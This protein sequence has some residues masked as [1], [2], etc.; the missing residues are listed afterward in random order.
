MNNLLWIL[1][2]LFGFSLIRQ[3]KAAQTLVFD[4]SS[5]QI[6]G[7]VTNPILNVRVQV[8]NNTR[9]GINLQHM[10]GE[11]FLNNTKVG[12]MLLTESVRIE[13]EGLTILNFVIRDIGINIFPVIQ[14]LLRSQKYTAS[15]VGRININGISAPVE[16]SKNI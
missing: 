2:A 6:S 15:F 16:F 12:N 14:N 11:L 10:G 9:A 7:G 5:L 4:F 8:M 13:P 3:G 1:A